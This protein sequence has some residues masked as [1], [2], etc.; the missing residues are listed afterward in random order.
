[1][2]RDRRFHVL[3]ERFASCIACALVLFSLGTIVTP[4]VAA[5]DVADL[6]FVC[7]LINAEDLVRLTGTSW[8]VA[9]HF[10]IQ[11]GPKYKPMFGPLV[12]IR[13]D[14]HEVHRLYPT[15]ESAVDWDRTTY[16]DCPMPPEGLSS[17]GLNVRPLGGKKFRL[18]VANH[19]ERESVEIIDVSAAEP[20]LLTTWRGCIRAPEGIWPNGVVPLPNGGVALSGGGVAIWRPGHGWEAIAGING[21]NGIEVSRDATSL[22]VAVPDERSVVRVP[23]AGGTVQTIFKSDFLTDNM[24]WGEDGHLYVAGQRPPEGFHI[25]KCLTVSICDIGFVVAQIDPDTLKTKE[26][27]RSDGIKSAFGAATT[28]LQVGSRFWIG[29]FSGD[30]V[31]LIAVKP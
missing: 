14:T 24:R 8:I 29:S 22:F 21:G 20:Q 15:P 23:V 12:A 3:R 18:Y 31:M 6:R 10:N 4:A 26:I 30:R 9:S 19:G 25:E 27:H 1:M 5:C 16:P 28:A 2:R 13:V 7:G 17:H 11:P